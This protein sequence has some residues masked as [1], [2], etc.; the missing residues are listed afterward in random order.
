MRRDTLV[1][2]VLGTATSILLGAYAHGSEF[3]A[4]LSGFAEVP[5][6]ILSNGKGRLEL[7]LNKHAQTIDFK[8]TY[9]GLTTPATQAHIHFGKRHVVGGI[10]VFFC[11]NLGNGPAGTPGCPSN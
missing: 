9:S 2:L 6:S 4:R 11:T 8:L 1:S 7:D 10:M 3:S 5:L